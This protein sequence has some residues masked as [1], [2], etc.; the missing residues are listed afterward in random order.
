MPAEHNFSGAKPRFGS[1]MQRSCSPRAVLASRAARAPAPGPP[2]AWQA[3]GCPGARISLSR[4]CCDVGQG[5]LARRAMAS[6]RSDHAIHIGTCRRRWVGGRNGSTTAAAP[7]ASSRWWLAWLRCCTC[8]DAK[9]ADARPARP[10]HRI[11]T[12]VARRSDSC[13]ALSLVRPTARKLPQSLQ[14]PGPLRASGPRACGSRRRAGRNAVCPY[15][16]PSTQ[17]DLLTW[18]PLLIPLR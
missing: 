10:P 3:I 15:V 8:A 9:R 2:Y 16:T 14:P 6:R 13:R 5:A 4:V 18:Q 17:S 11:E 12:V 7:W 1:G